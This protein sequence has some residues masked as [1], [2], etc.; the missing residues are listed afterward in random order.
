MG[1]YILCQGKRA[2]TPFYIEAV[3]V[4]IYSAEELCY[5]FC[6]D[7]PLLDR[8]ILNEN[9]VE[10]LYGELKLRRLARKLSAVLEQDFKIGEFVIPVLKEI[11]YLNQQE[12]KKLEEELRRL[13]EEP[14]P[15]RI[16]R[17]GDSLMAH[18][19]YTKAIEAYTEALR[20]EKKGSL[21]IQFVGN[22]YNNLGCAYSRLFQMEEACGCFRKA[23]ETL[24]TRDTLKSCLFAVYLRD[25]RRAYE[26]LAEELKVDPGTREEMDGQIEGIAPDPY[27]EDLDRSLAEWTR[28]YHRNTG[29]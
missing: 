18:E 14:A 26:Q 25:G 17:R 5:Y 8:S 16:K 19:K 9:L 13:E 12:L 15:Q 3:G 6:T 27:P 20:M 11:F 24:H 4:N 7:Y 2:E 22:L 21:G 1:C 10:W 29:L 23:Y 28:E